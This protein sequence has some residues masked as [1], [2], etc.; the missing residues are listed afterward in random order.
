MG[1][2][3]NAAQFVRELRSSPLENPATP[4]G[5]GALGLWGGEPTESG[6]SI[7]EHTAM[8]VIA[9]YACIRVLAESVGSL[10]LPLYE[11]QNKGRLEAINT[12]LHYL[13]T[14]EPNPEMAAT[15]FFETITGCMAATGNS[16][17]QVVRTKSGDIAAIYPLH[18][19][20]TKPVRLPARLAKELNQ[21]NGIN[22]NLG[23]ETSDGMI[24]GQVRVL[25]LGEVLHFPLFG[26]DGILGLNPIHQA[27]QAIGLAMATEKFG[28]R[29]FG[30]GARPGGVLSTASNL[31]PVQQE[32]VRQ[33]WNQKQGGKNQGKTAVLWGDWKYTQIGVSP[34]DSQ[35]LETRKMS[36]EDIAGLFRVPPQMIG[37]VTRLSNSNHEQQSLQFVTDTL[38]PYLSRIECEIRRKL[39]PMRGQKA[40][41]MFVQFDVRARLRGDFQTT[42]AGLALGRQWGFMTADDCREA[43]DENPLPTPGGDVVLFPLNMGNLEALTHPAALLPPGAGQPK[44][45]TAGEPEPEPAPKPSQ[46]VEDSDPEDEEVQ[47]RAREFDPIYLR[48]FRDSVGRLTARETRDPEAVQ[49]IFG[50]LLTSLLSD[51]THKAQ[52]RFAL[53]GNW[54]PDFARILGDQ[55]RSIAKRAIDWSVET[56]NENAGREMQKAVK[57]IV[58]EVYR[59]AAVALAQKENA[60]AVQS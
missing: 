4:L 29:Y 30:N 44:Q 50:P 33:S 37:D 25:G 40:N 53:D 52:L 11:R 21:D 48:T 12:D 60:Y 24:E 10:P 6:E 31:T 42:M 20:K 7:N 3:R 45:L 47:S 16:Y 15:V 18:P 1:F 43:I 54:E 28:A 8:R 26:F 56:A 49:A 38:R 39:L 22:S 34:E 55:Y 17:A 58:L 57:H 35:F 2:F 27:R 5:L 59:Q 32:E 51:S 36:R 23:Y 13:L 9:V 14:V 19:L 41:K 46:Q